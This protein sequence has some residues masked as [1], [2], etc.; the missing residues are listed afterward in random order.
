[1]GDGP[2][3][4]LRAALADEPEDE[5]VVLWNSA[6]Q[7]CAVDFDVDPAY[8]FDT[9]S[10]L[11]LLDRHR[12]SPSL[13]WTTHGGGLRLIYAAEGD[14]E[15]DGFTAE[16]VA[17]VS[18]LNL[19]TIAPY[20]GLEL[21][22]ET[23]HPCSPDGAGRRGGEVLVREQQFDVRSLWRHLRV[24]E[25]TD[26]EVVEWLDS[27]GMAVGS[28]Y[29]HVQCPVAPSDRGGRQPVF[30][31]DRGVHC[32]ICEAAGVCAGS[33][34]AGFFP[35]A[36]L[37]GVP[38]A[39]LL[40]QCLEGPSHWEHARYL[41][42]QTLCVP[43]RHARLVYGAGVALLRGRLLSR[44]CF[45]VGRDLVRLG[46]RWANLCG[47]SYSGDIRPILAT[48]PAATYLDDKGRP[49]PDRARVACLDQPHDL[50]RY[51]YPPL[52]PVFGCR[53]WPEDLVNDGPAVAV[54][55]T[56]ELSHESAVS[57]R[58]SLSGP[59]MP[60]AEVKRIF[61]EAFPGLHWPLL[62]L[63]V[64]A[65]GVAEGGRDMPPMVFVTGPSG[66][67]KSAT[68]HLAASVCGD[69][70]R[71]VVWNA[72]SDRVR[73]AVMEA[74]SSGTFVTFNEV[75]K[76]ARRQIKRP[77]EA[78]DYAL[79]LTSDSSSHVLYRGP[80]EMGRLPVFVWTDTDLVEQIRK[81]AQFARRIVHVRLD[82]SV[83]WRESLRKSGVGHPK[84]FRQ[85]S[86]A[87]ARA[88]DAVLCGV[89]HEFLRPPT[90]FD[91][92]ARRLGFGSLC[93]SEE[94]DDG[95]KLLLD[96]FECTCQ[97]PPPTGADKVRWPGP[98]WRVLQRD[99]ET[100]LRAAWMAV[101]DEE[102][103][104]TSRAAQEVDWQRVASLTEPTRLEV[105]SH[106]SRVALRFVGT[107]TRQ[108]NEELKCVKS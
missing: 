102:S 1:M 34:R 27:R 69:R 51:G 7:M 68:P 8:A 16:E 18:L 46:D 80:R 71:E 58:P 41:V 29:D 75:L 99:H 84:R 31:G 20:V 37:C 19:S 12:P 15:T 60:E 43:Q 3:A 44:R 35:F 13:A 54:V 73:Q 92:I 82:S 93:D 49:K 23:R 70:N 104:V 105:R 64:A 77:A 10:L 76:E 96:L 9:A 78:M 6:E 17:A 97:A 5:S 66:A 45:A 63:L 55:Q 65:R 61:D 95:R 24:L 56:R 50:S 89:V 38:R 48:L 74:A 87:R 47:E 106:G 21:K 101:A 88:C 103:F 2:I 59:C 98:G 40:Q 39:S 91:D 81:D 83:D 108:T 67:G 42:E 85:S 25:A 79:N 107:L 53:M 11:A 26:S 90:T 33:S 36:H 28:R 62:R 32:F 30:V 14:P 86:E 72:N 52:Q 57:L 4:A 94:A 100:P 22:K